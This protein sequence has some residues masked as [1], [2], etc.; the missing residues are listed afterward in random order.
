MDRQFFKRADPSKG[1]F[2]SFML[3][4]LRMFLTDDLRR[5]NSQKRGGDLERCLIQEGD[6][7]TEQDDLEFDQSWAEMVFQRSLEKV[8]AAALKKR[9]PQIWSL[10]R[11]FLPGPAAM[12]SY[13]YEELGRE[14][15]LTEGGAKT[16]VFRLRQQF[17]ENLRA[18][19]AVTVGAPHEVDEELAHLRASLER[20]SLL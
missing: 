15:G 11:T 10:L 4:S 7:T 16:E 12:S 6:I 18:E 19:V 9:N 8:E 13:T 17:R 1:R 14:L 20:S 2:R 5:R 3:G